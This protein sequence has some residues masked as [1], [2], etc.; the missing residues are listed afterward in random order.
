M[1]KRL[2][3]LV[4][5]LALCLGLTVP[6]SAEETASVVWLDEDLVPS[7][8][9]G[10]DDGM[11]GVRRN[12]GAYQYGFVDQTGKLVIPLQYSE[13][14]RFTEG[15]APVSRARDSG[16]GWDLW[17][18]IDKNGKEVIPCIYQLADN[19]SEGL[20]AVKILTEDGEYKC[21]Y[22]D[23]TG[24]VVIPFEYD[25]GRGF[26]DGY[27]AVQKNGKWGFIDK[28]GAVVIPFEY[29]LTGLGFSNG[30]AEVYKNGKWGLINENNEFVIPPEL[31]YSDILYCP[32]WDMLQ[33]RIGE[34]GDY[35]Y[36][37]ID[38]DGTTK[39][40]LVY[41]ECYGVS[42]GLSAARFGPICGFLDKDGE[43]AIPFLY[44]KVSPFFE[45]LAAVKQD[46]KTGYIN[47]AGEVVIPFEYDEAYSFSDGVALVEK[48]G[49]FGILSR[50][51]VSSTPPVSTVGG[52]SDVKESN[53]FADAVLWAVEKNITS[54]T[55]KTTFSPNATCSKAQILSFLWR[56]NGS[57][58]PTAANPFTDVKTNDYFYK[59]ALWA[60]E[61]GLVSGSTFGANADC[62]RAMTVEYMWKAAGSPAPAG[63]ADFDDVPANADYAQAVAWAVENKVTSG[64]GGDNFSP[65][66]TCTRGQIV[67]FL[68]RA[69]G[70]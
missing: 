55:S 68:H 3:S 47:K 46:G 11:M 45:G 69:M 32:E 9:L 43:W 53:Y 44:S 6:A 14:M 57:P 48:D 31:N 4:L 38:R 50:T 30:L 34:Y 2:F 70:K 7:G 28:S 35:R 61:K 22:I 39:I 13:V 40:L 15:L 23:K 64:T 51:P 52:F 66:A 36:G 21:G 12:K 27:A 18:Y 20:A 56:A 58:E 60:A 29:G 42:E 19:F 49:R 62:T 17:G 26:F 33:V 65:A 41:N 25:F 8:S 67:S 5:A 1:K 10:F 63:K 24:K 37:F 54:G 16:R 59:A